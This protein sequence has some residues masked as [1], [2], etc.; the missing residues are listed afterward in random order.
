MGC[1]ERY[2]HLDVNHGYRPLFYSGDDNGRNDTAAVSITVTF[3]VTITSTI[4][5]GVS[6]GVVICIALTISIAAAI[7]VL[8]SITNAIVAG[9]AIAVPVCVAVAIAI[10]FAFAGCCL[11]DQRESDVWKQA[12]QQRQ[13]EARRIKAHFDMDRCKRP[14]H[15]QRFTDRRQLHCHSHGVD[16]F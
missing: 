10:A 11:Q 3:A 13:D 8:V 15:F 16:E 12:S 14:L 6:I 4:V 1:C 9:N 2:D 7:T 5:I